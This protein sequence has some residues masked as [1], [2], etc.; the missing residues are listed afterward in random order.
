MGPMMFPWQKENGGWV[1]LRTSGTSAS[2]SEKLF[3]LSLMQPGQDFFRSV[4]I[5][6]TPGMK[7]LA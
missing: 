7:N 4:I 3:L 5:H 2:K 6:L 1:V